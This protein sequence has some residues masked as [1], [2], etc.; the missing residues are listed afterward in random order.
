M[1]HGTP[2][3]FTAFDPDRFGTSTDSGMLGR[4]IYLAPDAG[5]AAS[6]ANRGTAP[7]VM[8]LYVR[9]EHPFV[10][11][12]GDK[13]PG[14]NTPLEPAETA[15]QR[16]SDSVTKSLKAHGYDGVIHRG[17]D[18]NIEQI[19]AFDPDQ[20]KSATGNR[21]TF[22]SSNPDIRYS[23]DP[24]T[25]ENY[26]KRIDELF[27]TEEP[28]AY[29]VRALDHSDMLG[30][31][32]DQ[33]G[34]LHIVEKKA[35]DSIFNHGLTPQ[36]WKHIPE[37]LD[38]PVAVFDSETV[39]GR[40]VAIAPELRD[41]SPIRMILDPAADGMEVNLLV[42]AYDARGRSP[43]ARWLDDGLLRY[44]NKNEARGW[45]SR[46]G[47]R[48]PGLLNPPRVSG[49]KIL[50]QRDLV[51]YRAARGDEPRY[52]RDLLG[53]DDS[54]AG[55]LRRQAATANADVMGKLAAE[56]YGME[57]I[58]WT[59]NPL[60]YT[61]WRG[62]IERIRMAMLD[63]YDPVNKLQKAITD[64][65]GRDLADEAN[66]YRL[67]NLMHGRAGDR[68]DQL[69][70]HEVKP[71]IKSMRQMKVSPKLLQDYLL[72]RHAEERNA[73]VAKINPD[74]PDAGAGITTQQ[75]R[76]I[77]DGNA[78]GV[79]SG[80]RITDENRPKLER[81]AKRIDRINANTVN[82]M[83][84]SGQ[85]T[86]EL[87]AQLR[88]MY[89]HY[90]PLVGKIGEDAERA[91]T[92]GSAG[93]GLDIKGNPIKRA[94]GR[95]EGNLPPPT[96]LAEVIGQ[97]QRAVIQAE[98]AR[99]GRA[100]L[101]LAAEH[102]N[103][104]IWQVEPVDLEW[105][106]SEATGQAYLGTRKPTNDADVLTVVH[107][108]KAYH[109]R[110]VDP[111]IRDAVKNLGA[112]KGDAFVRYVG[113]LN[114]WLAAVNTRY[115]PAFLPY[116][117]IR[118]ATLGFTGLAAEQGAGVALDAAK[119][120]LPAMRASW[121]DASGAPGRLG[122]PVNEMTMDDFAREYG[123]NGGKT[124]IVRWERTADTAKKLE[125]NFKTGMQLMGELRPLAATGKA[126]SHLQPITHAVE[127][128]NDAVENSLRLAAYTA[129]RKRGWSIDKAAAYAKD[130]T[131]NFNRKGQWGSIMNSLFLFYNAAVQGTRRGV[132][133][134]KNPKV[135]GFLGALATLQASQTAL[136]MSRQNQ[137]GISDWDAI[138]EWKKQR[139]LIIA[140][141]GKG[142]Y[143]ALPM[144]Y[145]FGFTT[146]AGG[147][148]MQLALNTT[149][150][151]KA[152]PSSHAN[153]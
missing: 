29:G 85:I 13:L 108:G 106:Y 62:G 65:L 136:L 2:N 3:D 39:P 72:A 99:V 78:D 100:V 88:A 40:L 25:R 140:L 104:D 98:K 80:Q 30:M 10:F 52:S 53:D 87:A 113:K 83:E 58:G 49:E 130:L 126:L 73:R 121:R 7:R 89:K 79:Y 150:I 1:Y 4:G 50:T 35:L 84:H 63:K 153:V 34:P 54:P 16:Y 145:E 131:V 15:P 105:R 36:D 112:E 91:A 141:P 70:R 57:P 41:G 123:A 125:D 24:V 68:L 103:P 138:P 116:N 37:W 43:M 77:L 59:D 86:P 114:R 90:I 129:L 146:Y 8:P 117:A 120:Y 147:R 118:D 27:A 48:L 69:D 81:L 5:H 95:G 55:K 142:H 93:R 75:A 67:E 28:N 71:L 128:A 119:M 9:L 92:V 94:L 111:R 18:G 20:V 47:L 64:S 66:V 101:K 148:L 17:Q 137:D 122:L 51:K 61:G 33:N 109:V 19:V 46:S 21:G 14:G 32:E 22:D 110:L 38:N 74:M 6:Y 31:L 82:I 56:G 44:V 12:N 23:R 60:N 152:D 11:K 26:E 102:P 42:N 115:N 149:G 107:G 143:F 134:M 132:T 76:D 96:I 127:L 124:G 139:A 144:P 45:L 97:A 133:L 151:E 135:Q